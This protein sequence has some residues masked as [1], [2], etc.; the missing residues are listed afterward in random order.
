M[1]GFVMT[2]IGVGSAQPL[3]DP[4]PL[5][6]EAVVDPLYSGLC[7]TDVHLFREGM[8]LDTD[9]LPMV[10][11]HE[12]VGRVLDANAAVTAGGRALR[13]G[14]LVAV[15]PVLP[16]GKCHFCARGLLN[17]CLNWSHLGIVRDG[18]WAE[19]V[20]VPGP[21]LTVLP[22][23][24]DVRTATLA[25]PLACAVNFVLDR[26]E[27]SAGETVIILGAG[28]VGLLSAAVAKAAG[29]ATVIVSEPQSG[30][31]DRALAVGADVAVNPMEEDLQALAKDLTD[32]VGAD[33][34]IEVTGAAPAIAQSVDIAA[35]GSRVVLAGL[36]GGRRVPIDTNA[37][38]IKQ[39]DV[40]GGF[41]SRWAMSRGLA[42]LASGSLSIDSLV[43]SERSWA[44]AETAMDDMLHD[45]DTCKIVLTSPSI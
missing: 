6:G 13:A 36:G 17:L 14:D 3:N 33:V 7:G 44:D 21:R 29:A 40:R 43:T 1:R 22:E 12:F 16:C 34:I 8:M 11:G 26:A 32:G 4:T 19:F 18:C 31:R 39:L 5:P 37:L 9:D 25:E 45:P 35:P 24:V 15:E 10:L 20:A 38:A 2:S 23:G 28:P 42:M 30:R 41:A 27:V